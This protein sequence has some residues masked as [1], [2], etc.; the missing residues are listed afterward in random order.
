MS[1]KLKVAVS[2]G[3]T[4]GHIFPGLAVAAALKARGHDVTIWMAGKGVESEAM[5][6]WEGKV[7]TVPSEG[8]QY[9]VSL[10]SLVAAAR[11]I[12]AGFNCI[13][14]MKKHRPEIVLGMGSYASFG[15]LFAAKMLR[16]PY[17]LHEANV[18]PGKA[19]K[20]FSR[21]AAK[22]AV[23]FEETRHYMQHHRVAGVGMPLRAELRKAA[24]TAVHAEFTDT[25]NVLIMGGSGGAR[26]LNELI[27]QALAKVQAKG[28]RV[29]AIH[30][31]GLAEEQKVRALYEELGVPNETMGFAHDMA[32]LY[33]RAH[34]AI[35]RSGASSCFE[36]AAFGLPSL[37][38]PFPFAA[39]D[40]QFANAGSF[41]KS[42][43]AHVIR[44]NDLD[45]DWLAEYLINFFKQPERLKAMTLSAGKIGARNSA[46]ALAD[47]IEQ[48]VA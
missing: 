17:V 43:A 24:G 11:M 7:V 35:C 45:L 4:G 40:H 29:H 6:E 12:K 3:G 14:L 18:I 5:K 46:E 20:V 9:G 47:V 28:F 27:P 33:Q 34:F 30:L 21:G 19:N 44:Q 31:S 1:R 2:C 10:R 41:E 36:L 16:I 26:A 22:I 8:L 23:A 37:L 38:I 13:P 15:P 25:L 48:T 42:G 39:N 32:A